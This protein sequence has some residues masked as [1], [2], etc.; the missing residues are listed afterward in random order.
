MP[1]R[2]SPYGPAHERRRVALLKPGVLCHFGCGRQASELDHVPP[3]A[4][5]DHVEGSG[6]CRSLP[7][8]WECQREQAAA[9][10]WHRQSP[11]VEERFAVG[12]PDDSPGPDDP[13][14]DRAP[15]LERLRVVPADATWPR[16]MTFPHSAAVGSYGAEAVEWLRANA[17]IRCRWWQE[18][19]LTRQLEHD[20]DGVLVWLT[21]LETTA[22]QVGKSTLLRGGAT[23]RLHRS[24]LFGEEQTIMHTGKDLAVCKE[25]QRPARTWAKVRGYQVFEGNGAVQISEPLSGSRWLVRAKDG[26]YG[27]AV[28]HGLVD[29]AWGVAP[30]IVEDGLEPTMAE[31]SSAQLVLASTAHSKATTL[32]PT[33]RIAALDQL[34]EPDSTTRWH[35]ANRRRTGRGIV[36]GSSLSA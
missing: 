16:Y 7:A 4:L 33:H 31:R 35:G 26:V 24:E 5:H 3:L 20:R 18:L 29:E 6:C 8:C 34:E 9:L 10:G 15:W 32:F 23:W 22:R 13:V 28:S 21:A 30:G 1:R 17:D 25:V 36:S 2:G 19:A 11:P 14:W 27:Y 12:E